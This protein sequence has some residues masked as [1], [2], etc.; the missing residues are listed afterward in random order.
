VGNRRF[1]ERIT[2]CQWRRPPIT[3]E[4]ATYYPGFQTRFSCVRNRQTFQKFFFYDD[5]SLLFNFGVALIRNRGVFWFL[6]TD[7][8][9]HS[10]LE[11]MLCESGWKQIFT[12][13]RSGSV[14]I[15]KKL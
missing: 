11:S 2:F 13:M 1:P 5:F 8:L 3:Q 14:A 6:N 9:I 7:K 12:K 15:R 10:E 4:A